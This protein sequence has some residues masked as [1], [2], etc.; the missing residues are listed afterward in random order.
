M[1]QII[2]QFFYNYFIVYIEKFWVMLSIAISLYKMI[3]VIANRIKNNKEIVGLK[4]YVI[5]IFSILIYHTIHYNIFYNLDI[6]YIVTLLSMNI[7]TIIYQCIQKNQHMYFPSLICLICVMYMILGI[8]TN[9]VIL[10]LC[11]DVLILLPTII[12]QIFAISNR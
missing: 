4:S 7:S 9:N 11:F 3:I 2:E 6:W 10:F 8:I 5:S 12:R 1:E